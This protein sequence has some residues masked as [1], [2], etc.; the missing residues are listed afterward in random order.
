MN[1]ILKDATIVDASNLELHLTKKD[2]CITNGVISE[3]AKNIVPKKNF[4]TIALEN[5]HISKGWLDTS[6]SFGEPGYEERETISNGLQTA[7]KSGFTSIILNPNTNPAPCKGADIGFFKNTASGFCTNLYPMGSFTQNQNGEHLAELYNMH[8]AGAVAFY[9]Y[10]KGI[11]NANL[12][13]IGLQYLQNF[14]GLL[15]LFPDNKHLTGKGIVNEGVTATKLG[16]KGK[17]NIAEELQINRD[18]ELLAYTGGRLHIPTIS[19]TGAVNKIAQAKKMGLK[20]SCSVALQ[21]LFFDDTVLED[22]NSNYK[23]NPPLRDKKDVAALKK[24][25]INGIIDFV[26]TDHTPLPLEDKR[27]EFDLASYGTVALEAAFGVLNSLFDLNLTIDILTRGYKNYN[28]PQPEINIGQMACLS[29]FNPSQ[30]FTFKEDNL[31][32]SSKNAAYLGCKL[33]GKV[34]GSINNNQMVLA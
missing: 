18:L 15:Y 23:V 17:P 26:T 8:Q 16:L 34:Y 28:L 11:Q 12:A 6:V 30:K 13:K 20:V 27:L 25:I 14:N 21:N 4:K 9:D 19:T 24:G 5:L 22:F 2:I 32:S 33:K 31:F 10:K 3:I 1:I 7:A 29:L